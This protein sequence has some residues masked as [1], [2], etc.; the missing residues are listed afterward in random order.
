MEV[1]SLEKSVVFM[2]EE[3]GTK[4]L[5]LWKFPSNLRSSFW[6]GLWVKLKNYEREEGTV[7]NIGL[8]E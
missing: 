1:R 4:Y 8:C 6:Q 3:E 2:T 7:M 5:Q